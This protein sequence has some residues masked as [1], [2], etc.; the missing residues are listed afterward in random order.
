[1][2]FLVATPIGNLKDIS[3]R[4]IEVLKSCEYILCEDTRRSS[5]LMREYGVD[6]P[7]KSFYRGNEKEKED[8]IV[9][10]LKNG[11]NVAVVSDA[12]TPGICDPGERLVKR[13]RE[14][15]LEVT[16]VPG[17]CAWAVALSV[18]R[19]PREKV[20]FLGFF[21]KKEVGK[22]LSYGGTSIFYE[23]P[24]RIIETLELLGTRKVC[25]LRELTKMF[26]ECLEGT[27][28]ELV[29]HFKKVEPRGEMVVLVEGCTMDFTA[30]SEKDHVAWLK[31]EYDLELAEAIKV[32]AELR[33]I[34]KREIY[35]RVHH[36]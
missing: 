33:G 20:Q 25:V 10:D 15:G 9:S 19:M 8:A 34:P 17:A 2:L 27:A 30:M 31:K 13:C 7:L 28:E 35:K 22:L 21:D 29:G 1:M 18:S 12:G 16:A 5:I 11:K 6:R 4:A 32:A 36:E 14:E 3:F 23:A 24:H 26:E